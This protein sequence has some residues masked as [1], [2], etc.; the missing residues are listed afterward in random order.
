MRDDADHLVDEGSVGREVGVPGVDEL[1]DH[2]GDDGVELEVDLVRA[3]QGREELLDRA[4][5]DALLRAAATPAEDSPDKGR[6]R[7]VR[8]RVAGGR[9]SSLRTRASLGAASRGRSG[10]V[11][12][13]RR[14]D[15]VD[16]STGRL[17]VRSRRSTIRIACHDEYDL[18]RGN[19]CKLETPG[20]IVVPEAGLSQLRHSVRLDSALSRVAARPVRNAEPPP[21]RSKRVPRTFDPARR[22]VA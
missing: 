10:M 5:V 19:I 4:R 9:I 18:P 20:R 13:I 11:A 3:G 22:A 7:L 6:G 14:V 8:G 2:D 16:R 21:T 15:G 17:V 1:A 12:C